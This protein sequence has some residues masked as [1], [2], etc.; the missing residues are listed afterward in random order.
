MLYSV[1]I[2]MTL[3]YRLFALALFLVVTP[4][5]RGRTYS[6]FLDIS[7]PSPGAFNP[8]N[9][10]VVPKVFRAVSIDHNELRRQL[11]LAPK[12]ILGSTSFGSEIVLP[13]PDGT[14]QRFR[15][16]ESSI[17]EPGL[18]AQFPDIRTYVGQGIDDPTAT[19]RMDM[20]PA[21]FH[22]QILSASGSVYIDPRTR[23][24]TIYAS[25][26]K[27]DAAKTADWTCGVTGN[28]ATTSI[29]RDI[30]PL[31]A[32][33]TELRTYRLACA[34]TA[35]YTA[36]HG[37]TV[38][39]AMAAIVTAFNRVNGIYER[40]VAVRMNLVANNSSLVFLN[41]ITDDY[42]NDDG[43]LM[44]GENQTKVD[45]I[46]GS[47]N[48]DIGHV[49]STGGGGIASLGS[50][51]SVANKARGVTGS[52]SPIND[53][54]YVDYVCH[55]VGHQFDANHTFNSETGSC[56]GG[57]KSSSTAFEVGSGSTILGY[58]GICSPNDVQPLSDDYFHAGSLSEISSF[59][60][61]VAH[62]CPVKTSTGNSIPTVSAGSDFTI[63]RNTPFI[64]TA[65][66][67]DSN[68]DALTY[69]WEQMDL[70]PTA[71]LGAADTGAG[72][73]FRT[74]RPTTNN[75]RTFPALTNILANTTNLSERLPNTARTM[76]FRVTVRD[77]R[78][79]GGANNSDLALVT[80][81]TNAGPFL[82]TNLNTSGTFSGLV[83]VGWSVAGT[84][85]APVSAAQVKIMLSTNGGLTFPIT[86]TP[87]TPNTGSA[88]V[89]LPNITN[90]NARIMVQ[91][92]NNIFFDINDANLSIRPTSLGTA[93][94][95]LASTLLVSE[96]CAPTNGA[97]D[98][99]ETVSMWFVLGNYGNR[100]ASNITAT[101]MTTNGVLLPGPTVAYGTIQPGG[102]ATQTIAFT[103]GGTCGGAITPALRMSSGLNDVG[104]LST[105]IGLGAPGTAVRSLTNASLITIRDNNTALPYP[106][107]ITV[108]NAEGTISKVTVTLRGAN[109][110]L[111]YNI[112][113]MLVGPNGQ[114]V[115][116][117]GYCG[118]NPI[119]SAFLTFD[120]AA[121]QEVPFETLIVSGT[122]LPTSY[123]TMSMPPP[124]PAAPYSTKLSVFNGISPN[125]NWLLYVRDSELNNS[126]VI[127]NGWS[128]RIEA[129]STVC[130]D[131]VSAP[132][133]IQAFSAPEASPLLALNGAG[134]VP[135]GT[136]YLFATTNLM[137]PP[138]NWSRIGTN[139]SDVN[140]FF[141][142]T[143]VPD[144]MRPQH[145]YMIQTPP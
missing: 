74:Y 143:N 46:I 126:G 75:W 93:L 85:N 10:W 57:N 33:G 135:F 127:S 62:S 130:C 22:A 6:A 29:D 13:M 70:G 145:F 60:T 120:D 112:D 18:Q 104:T 38:T 56:G 8:A 142:F 15:F 95:Q 47:A 91:G 83:T 114:K 59:I 144:P 128:I 19:L 69:C 9:D 137:I 124:A 96:N 97:L 5:L 51:C 98:P 81:A 125:G 31:V 123:T 34:A 52:S 58:A 82:I 50:V 101:L 76:N 42:T 32:L 66:A 72:P 107:T 78:A 25:Y 36:F 16:S 87:N 71:D 86:L 108:A 100:A 90:N 119:N 20:T 84:T 11:N 43:G 92:V 110:Q 2:S 88:S 12:E 45:S 133:L 73:L 53:P 24:L 134:G 116:L 1:I 132:S 103:V 79:G 48:Y 102:F 14:N 26:F 94:V 136:N 67:T 39:G 68:G 4:E 30:V 7:P 64:L 35:E 129:A 41:A 61:D 139:I 28:A 140:G 105:S 44:L 17:M 3:A 115:M 117:M 122:Y 65:S 138:T 121:S 99:G 118:N 54:F 111:D 37:G 141:G 27:R 113:A 89:L 49:F 21:G 63:P 106:S 131:A 55:E 77:N 80:V 23:D 40:E 109:H